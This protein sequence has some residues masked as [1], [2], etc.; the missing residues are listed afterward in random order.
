MTEKELAERVDKILQ[1]D[2]SS[3]ARNLDCGLRLELVAEFCPQWVANE[4]ARLLVG[5]AWRGLKP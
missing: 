1:C 4:M 5:S 2:D 3:D